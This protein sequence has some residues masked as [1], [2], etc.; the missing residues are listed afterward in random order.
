M[1]LMENTPDTSTVD[2][3]QHGQPR[4]QQR[5]PN[6]STVLIFYGCLA[7]GVVCVV[8]ILG[9][10]VIV[11]LLAVVYLLVRW[12][13]RFNTFRMAG[14][15]SRLF[16]ENEINSEYAKSTLKCVTSV[17][18]HINSIG[19]PSDFSA[20]TRKSLSKASSSLVMLTG[21]ERN[22]ELMGISAHRE[23]GGAGSD[24]RVGEREGK[25]NVREDIRD[26]VK[27]IQSAKINVGGVAGSAKLSQIFD[28]DFFAQISMRNV[29]FEKREDLEEI[30]KLGNRI[31]AHC[32]EIRE[33]KGKIN[34]IKKLFSK[35]DFGTLHELRLELISKY[36]SVRVSIKVDSCSTID[37]IVV[38]PEKTGLTEA[39]QDDRMF[40]MEK[41]I[42]DSRLLEGLIS[43]KSDIDLERMASMYPT[44]VK[45]LTIAVY[46]LPNA[47]V[48]ELSAIGDSTML[49]NLTKNG[50]PLLMWNYRGYGYSTGSPS[51]QNLINDGKTIARFAKHGLGCSK[52]MVYGRSIGGHVA[53]A[54]CDEADLLIIDRSFSSISMVP[55]IMFE[56]RWIQFGFDMLLDNFHINVDKLFHSPCK[57]LVFVDPCNDEVITY[58]NSLAVGITAEA[59]DTYLKRRHVDLEAEAGITSKSLYHH[60]P[61]YRKWANARFQGKYFDWV[62]T[63]MD[64]SYAIFS[65]SEMLEMYT[66]LKAICLGLR[67]HLKSKEDQAV[68]QLLINVFG[69]KDRDHLNNSSSSLNSSY[70]DEEAQTN[71]QDLNSTSASS[72]AP[73]QF[74][75]SNFHWDSYI[76]MLNSTVDGNNIL[77]DLYKALA[78]VQAGGL[79]LCELLSKTTGEMGY[80][81]FQCLWLNMFVWGDASRAT[82]YSSTY[83][84]CL[85]R[86]IAV[87]ERVDRG[88]REAG[89]RMI[90][91]SDGRARGWIA[92]TKKVRRMVLS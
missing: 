75:Q 4:Q 50:V 45:D 77:K 87:L 8:K 90:G 44:E 60:I 84:D 59:C 67:Y 12:F 48:F 5:D 66:T 29:S 74:N 55:R 82:L 70:D 28:K 69:S 2:S 86:E 22:Y 3:A 34:S 26:M 80:E 57:K 13:A 89:E 20:A 19:K 88:I 15:F 54:L 58:M 16:L 9:V 10:K 43:E 85:E 40:R 39:E 31:K 6:A 36:P 92:D 68:D 33:K 53:K 76:E 17:L 1:E 27:L 63:S 81:L 91:L 30:T 24:G 21:L 37:A 78:E 64:A 25:R 7:L 11:V 52:L 79:Y 35:K 61:F 71:H 72:T 18:E 51:M 65:P 56:A 38:L 83:R 32:T 14:Y 49:D 42:R 73:S 47:G 23:N 46:C 62:L 41:Q